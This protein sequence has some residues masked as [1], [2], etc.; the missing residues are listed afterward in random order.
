[1]RN[2]SLTN[3]FSSVVVQSSL[4]GHF[5]FGTGFSSAWFLDP[6]D[7]G[8]TGGGAPYEGGAYG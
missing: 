2:D 1:M 4:L 8:A 3:F 5:S 6:T 7:K